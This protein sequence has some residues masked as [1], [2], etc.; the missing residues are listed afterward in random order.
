MALPDI[1]GVLDQLYGG[2]NGYNLSLADRA[3]EHKDN[4]SFTYGEML[5]PSFARILELA[6]PQPGETFYDLGSGT[7]KV[8]VMADLLHDFAKVVGIEFLPTLNAK[9]IELL[10]RYETGLRPA[11]RRPAELQARQGDMLA[12]DLSDADIVFVHATCMDQALLDGLAQRALGCKP[13]TRFIMISRGFFAS[14]DYDCTVRLEFE[15]AWK[16][17]STAY[18]YRLSPAAAALTRAQSMREFEP[19][20]L[21]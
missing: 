4:K 14:R 6:A 10:A 1:Q 20:V 2:V 17:T 18:V 15:N 7:G 3:G 21:A 19:A 13:T 12:T 9:A 8:L 11:A 5:L 16:S